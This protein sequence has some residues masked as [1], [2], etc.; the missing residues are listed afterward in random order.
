M[1]VAIACSSLLGCVTSSERETLASLARAGEGLADIPN[2]REDAPL[3][4]DWDRAE[5]VD[6]DGTPQAYVDYALAHHNGLRAR[7]ERWRAATHRVARER[8][9]PMPALTYT[10]RTGV[11]QRGDRSLQLQQRQTEPPEK[12]TAS[13]GGRPIRAAAVVR[14]FALVATRMPT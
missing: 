9:L 13:A 14:T 11:I 12:A 8:R 10:E 3:G 2:T 6:L 7:W 1:L 5:D 4:D